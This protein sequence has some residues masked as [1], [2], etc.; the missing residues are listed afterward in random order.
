MINDIVVFVSSW[1]LGIIIINYSKFSVLLNASHK[2]VNTIKKQ[3]DE[4]IG[5]LNLKE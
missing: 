1:N 5:S 3:C 4:L 2:I